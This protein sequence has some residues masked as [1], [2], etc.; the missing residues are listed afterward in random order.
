MYKIILYAVKLLLLLVVSSNVLSQTEIFDIVTY[1]P[2]KGFKKDTKTGVITYTK[3]NAASGGYCVIAMY[4]SMPGTGDAQKDFAKDWNQ[5]V[6]IPFNGEVN[7]KTET[8]ST[9]DG[10]KV[11]VGASLV[12]IDGTDVYMILTVFSGF[13]KSLS[14]RSSL[15]EQSF[16]AEIDALLE[17]MKLDKTVKA[18][19]DKSNNNTTVAPSTGSNGQFRLMNY[20]APAGWSHQV[21]ADGVV[22]KPLDLAKGEHLAIQ[23]ME[24]LNLSGT[25]EQAL[26]Q[27]YDEAALMY[28][29]TKM[30]YAGGDNYQKTEPKLSFNGWEYIEGKG[31]V[32]VENGTP[33]K[34][35]LGLDLFVIKVNNRFERI[36]VLKSRTN[37]NL[38]RYYSTDRR[39]YSN[40]I[41]KFLF[42]LRFN[43]GAKRHFTTRH[44]EWRRYYWS[45]A[46]H[47]F[48]GGSHNARRAAWYKV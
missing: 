12:K 9:P 16:T 7:P 18:P 25:L 3:V 20:T 43:D 34:T 32:Q 5:L 46:R 39:A 33:Y 26:R 17:T 14:I 24:P 40:A 41:E 38:S 29:S 48:I 15:N 28:N 35:E 11:I 2:P 22:F 4:A 45:L 21:F 42:T 36:A 27:S 31:G 19:P 1:S 37:C 44:R 23:I 13:G 10:W 6:V 30:H 8:Q 47:F